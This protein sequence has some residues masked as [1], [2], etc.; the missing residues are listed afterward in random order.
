MKRTRITR[1][2]AAPII[3]GGMA[4]ALTLTACGDDAEGGTGGTMT[5]TLSDTMS[6]SS[7]RTYVPI[8]DA[9]AVEVGVD[10]KANHVAG[11]GHM[12]TVLQQMSSRTLPD[13]L[14]LDNS[15]VQQI[16]A[17][18]ALSDLGDYGIT[19]EG[20]PEVIVD[21]GSYD[22]AY[23]GIAPVVNAV[24]LIYNEDLLAEAGIT[25]PTTWDEL[26]AAAETLTTDGRYGI[27]FSGAA[28]LEGAVHYLPFLWS[29]GGTEDD[30]TSP[31][32]VEAL[33][34]MTS[35]VQGGSA[36]ASVVNWSQ[37]DVNDQFIAGNAA[38]MINGP[39]NM[40][41]LDA[42]ENLSYGVVQVPVPEA[43]DTSIAALGGETFTV[44]VTK[45][46]ERMKKAG[47]FVA[48]ITSDEN[49][50]TMGL[51]RGAIPSSSTAAQ[52]AAA[53]VPLIAG[54]VDPVA[55]ARP[56]TGLLGEDWPAAQ[57]AIYTA[58][59]SALTGQL[60]PEEALNQAAG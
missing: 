26:R 40:P 19:G 4:L 52:Q 24:G 25:P 31:E 5:L 50:L 3:V 33:E 39:W 59:Q 17:S 29:N 55:N 38:M 2:K 28:S 14:M 8:Y 35:L 42:A 60:S 54:F 7:Q 56:R 45:D 36:S 1:G 41:K 34:F 30:L 44:P 47:E 37:N 49:Q 20:F 6:E 9:C 51:G 15:D 58:V 21:A 23:Y 32:A 11:S 27:A 13:V 57:T 48:C 12:K 16:A 46:A 43:G 53:Q 10:I 18:G 22:G